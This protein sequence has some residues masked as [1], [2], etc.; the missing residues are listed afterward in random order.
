VSFRQKIF[1]ASTLVVVLLAAITGIVA[2][3]SGQKRLTRGIEA[4][5]RRAPTILRERLQKKYGAFRAQVDA[6]AEDKRY[7]SWLARASAA[8]APAGRLASADLKAAHDGLGEVLYSSWNQFRVTN[9]RGVLLY[10]VADPDALGRDLSSD[11]AVQRAL[12]GDEVLRVRADGAAPLLEMARAVT[13]EGDVRG[14]LIAGDSLEPIRAELE[15]ALRARVGIEAGGSGDGSVH[16]LERDGA[17]WLKAQVSIPG[18]RPGE[19]IGR[20]TLERSLSAELRPL[21]R[22]LV[23]A[24]GLG[25]AAGLAV[26]VI[27]SLLLARA[28]AAPVGKLATATTE[29]GHGNFDHRVDIASRDELGLLGRAFNQMAAGL[30]QRVFFE[31]ALRRYLAAPVVE[32]LIR[33]PSKLQLGG[34]KR[35]V[36][37]LFFDVAGFTSLAEELPADELV[38]LVNRYLDE[39]VAAIF[40]Y[41]GT[42]DK[43]I[44]DAVMAFWGAPLEQ[45]DH[46]ARACRAATEMQHAFGRFVDQHADARI[47]ALRGRVGLHT[48]VAALGNLGST[49]I[50]NYTA[51][52]DTV[53]VASRLEGINKLYGTSI[54]A[55]EETVA[56]AGWPKARELD[57]V[58]VRGRQKPLRIF[59]LF[60]A[61]ET[62][63]PDALGAYAEGLSHLRA[64]RFADALAAFERASAWG[65]GACAGVMAVRA[66]ALAADP[67]PP[68]WDG[69]HNLITK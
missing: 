27:L 31:S 30:K 34:E 51:M 54:C 25:S 59:E 56:R 8:D 49:Y 64:R 15:S 16:T 32:Q 36:S 11:A 60:G 33:D 67:P 6:W 47:R 35:E 61:G 39:L 46:A 69:A 63:P 19:V 50:M 20:A 68:D 7:A 45:N 22:D 5:F 43:F 55:S 9:D 37:I 53:N 10:D 13:I 57:L 66:A 17:T 2:V 14:V 12:S 38:A 58:R 48:G 4:D 24:M 42:F 40:K 41:D 29:I 28:L 52:G 62:P 65:D 26:A 18:L 44:G 23:R 1:V 21:E 3:V